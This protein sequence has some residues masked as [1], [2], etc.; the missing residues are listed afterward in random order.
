MNELNKSRTD[1]NNIKEEFRKSNKSSLKLGNEK[2]NMEINIKN[3]ELDC[4]KSTINNLKADNE[5]N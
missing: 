1:L 2:L 5:K 3:K 4:L